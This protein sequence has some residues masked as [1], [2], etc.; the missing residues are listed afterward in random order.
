MRCVNSVERH[1]V[2][3]ER[4]DLAGLGQSSHGDRRAPLVGYSFAAGHS[5]CAP[6]ECSVN[7]NSLADLLGSLGDLQKLELL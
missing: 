6:G 1:A 2:A 7:R 5:L 3:S 4:C